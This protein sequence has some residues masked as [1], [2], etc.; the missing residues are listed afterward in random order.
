MEQR[1][2]SGNKKG[3]FGSDRKGSLE[4]MKKISR[5]FKKI[6]RNLSPSHEQV[7]RDAGIFRTSWKECW[8]LKNKLEGMLVS[9][10]Q[11]E[12]DAGVITRKGCTHTSIS[13]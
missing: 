7:E 8:Y 5:S 11:V 4:E 10:E 13:Q 2:Q 12:R 6:R 3:S 9:L 1:E